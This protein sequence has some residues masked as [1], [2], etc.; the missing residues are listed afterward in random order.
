MTGCSPAQT[1]CPPDPVL[2]WVSPPSG[3]KHRGR[4]GHHCGSNER[5][6]PSQ[7]AAQQDKAALNPR[8]AI[9]E[10]SPYRLLRVRSRSACGGDA[11]RSGGDGDYH[12]VLDLV[13]ARGLAL[14]VIVA[15]FATATGDFLLLPQGHPSPGPLDAAS[16]ARLGRVGPSAQP[17]SKGRGEDEGRRRTGE[18]GG[19]S[20]AQD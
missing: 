6:L 14:A 10:D 17:G 5:T 15:V 3:T 1:K 18:G 9:L 19:G 20:R 2:S 16:R 12:F 7:H 8:E 13:G 4:G 11:R